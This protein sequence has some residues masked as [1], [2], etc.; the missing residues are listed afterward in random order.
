M[1]PLCSDLMRPDLQYITKGKDVFCCGLFSLNV[2]SRHH[3]A[4]VIDGNSSLIQTQLGCVR[5]A[6]CMRAS[7]GGTGHECHQTEEEE[8]ETK[9]E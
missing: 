3:F 7:V 1:R 2:I 6:A 9:N 8:R 4:L 5:S